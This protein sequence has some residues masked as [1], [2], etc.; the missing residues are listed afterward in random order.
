MPVLHAHP[1]SKS[2]EAPPKGRQ[3]RKIGQ[4]VAFQNGTSL[5]PI[6]IQNSTAA[7][8]VL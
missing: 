3:N 5:Q 4:K 1:T 6:M 2:L 7:H 8:L